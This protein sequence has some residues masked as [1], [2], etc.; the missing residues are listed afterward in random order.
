MWDYIS[1]LERHFFTFANQ[2]LIMDQLITDE[3][4]LIPVLGRLQDRGFFV[5]Y[6]VRIELRLACTHSRKHSSFECNVHAGCAKREN[7]AYNREQMYSRR[8][9]QVALSSTLFSLC[10]T[11]SLRLVPVHSHSV[12][13][14]F[15]YTPH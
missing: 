9:A 1:T 8:E 2:N 6:H 10:A 15:L 5:A 4:L 11:T 3:E 13:S 12:C 14:I 7:Q